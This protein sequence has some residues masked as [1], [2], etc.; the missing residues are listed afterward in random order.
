[1]EYKRISKD[2]YIE[3]NGIFEKAE[4][5]ITVKS[6]FKKYEAFTVYY[7]NNNTAINFF[8][9]AS[10]TSR[11]SLKSV[12]AG[13]IIAQ[14]LE[15]INDI[16]NVIVTMNHKNITDFNVNIIEGSIITVNHKNLNK[17]LSDIPSNFPYGIQLYPDPKMYESKKI[18]LKY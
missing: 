2:N 17:N 4:K 1:M 9:Q 15:N 7:E 13:T 11:L 16:D 12:P 5:T 18:R 8:Y 3:K 14:A 10:P 6:P